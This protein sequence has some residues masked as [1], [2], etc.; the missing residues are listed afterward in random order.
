MYDFKL[1][2]RD[3]RRF[4]AQ[5]K[6]IK[7]K[8]V[9]KVITKFGKKLKELEEWMKK[10]K[11][12]P[13]FLVT[14]V[15]NLKL[16]YEML[17]DSRF[18][19]SSTTKRWIVFALA[20]FISPI[21]LVPDFIPIIGYFDDAAV[22][23]WVMDICSEEIDR[24]KSFLKGK[25]ATE[26]VNTLLLQRGS[27]NRRIIIA[28]GFLSRPELASS[29]SR[30]INSIRTVDKTA[31]IYAFV[32]DTRDVSL[33]FKS[34]LRTYA[35]KGGLLK[36]LGYSVDKIR[37]TWKDAKLNCSV[38]SPSLVNDIERMH[39]LSRKR[40]NVT[41]IGHSLGARLLCDAL[42]L[43]EKGMISNVFTVGGAVGYDALWFRHA[44]K[45]KSLYNCYSSNDQILS[46]L[47][48]FVESGEVPIGIRRIGKSDTKK[49]AEFD[50]SD[51]IF[52]HSDYD[53]RGADWFF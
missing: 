45:V 20:Y 14:F 21:D 51:F 35:L 27:S 41:L 31:H 16:L 25:K 6:K 28:T 13:D 33:L 11:Y 34:A 1:S 8:D 18:K 2:E 29:Y 36:A 19:I 49:R 22:L 15:R 5:A 38:Y 7:E 47:Y 9:I 4:E 48:K 39:S 42:G 12:I 43:A 37:T 50:C 40:L 46:K 10:A 17:C 53:K 44:R 30:W 23:L 26:S 3:K 32:W 52:G 24:Y